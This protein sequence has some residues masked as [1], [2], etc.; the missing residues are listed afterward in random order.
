[1]EQAFFVDQAARYGLLE[2]VLEHVVDYVDHSLGAVVNGGGEQRVGV[3]DGGGVELLEF[4]EQLD[5]A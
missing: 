1:M 5:E 2:S 3:L 4:A